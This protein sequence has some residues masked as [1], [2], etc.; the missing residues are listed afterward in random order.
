MQEIALREVR[1]N[2]AA[3]TGYRPSKGEISI[4][5]DPGKV[6][7]TP[8]VLIKG[9][10]RLQARE[11]E[12]AVRA[13]KGRYY[14]ETEDLLEPLQIIW[15]VEEGTILNSNRKCADVEFGIDGARAGEVRT[16]VVA[17]K[18]TERGGMGCTV[19]S[20]VFVQILLTGDD[21]EHRIRP[22]TLEDVNA[23]C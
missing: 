16:H 20:S 10:T 18:V 5:E 23:I 3:V 7:R 21:A 11:S 22:R 4:P 1:Q 6:V 9:D 19:H 14:I 17:A 12:S 15:M 2:N 13:I 8:K